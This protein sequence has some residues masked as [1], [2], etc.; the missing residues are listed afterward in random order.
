MSGTSDWN[1]IALSF[2]LCESVPINY[3]ANHH[4]GYLQGYSR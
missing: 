2:Y 4:L 3:A 1:L